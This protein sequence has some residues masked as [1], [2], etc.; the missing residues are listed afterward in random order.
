MFFAQIVLA[1]ALG[2][3]AAPGVMPTE[4]ELNGKKYLLLMMPEASIGWTRKR[5]DKRNR[6]IMFAFP[7]AFTGSRGHVDGFVMDRGV[8]VTRTSAKMSGAAV[9]C[10]GSVK[11]IGSGFGQQFDDDFIKRHKEAKCSVFEQHLLVRDGKPQDFDR[12]TE[13]RFQRRALVKFANGNVGIV[14]S[15]AKIGKTE[16]AEALT[17]MCLTKDACVTDALYLDMGASSEGWYRGTRGDVNVIDGEKDTS[18][19]SNWLV[20][21]HERG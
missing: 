13:Q 5:P 2:T 19:Q 6:E 9:I 7:A 15:G 11:I 3:P 18:R 21:R 12:S 4:W 14:Q 8:L 20:M 1:A 17:H 10:N 16:F